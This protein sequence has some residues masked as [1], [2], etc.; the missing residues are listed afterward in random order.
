MAVPVGLASTDPYNRDLEMLS[1][2]QKGLEWYGR[3][4]VLGS[5]PQTVKRRCA[6]EDTDAPVV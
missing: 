3:C 5:L 4:P 2:K 6:N 1:L